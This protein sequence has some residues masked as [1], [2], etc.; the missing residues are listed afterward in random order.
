MSDDYHFRIRQ[1][2]P[3]NSA[4][5]C[6]IARRLVRNADERGLSRR[7]RPLRVVRAQRRKVMR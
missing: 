3:D 4:M 5:A 7:R 2:E 6:R 1:T